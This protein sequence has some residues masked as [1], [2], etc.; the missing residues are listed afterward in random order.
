M[1]FGRPGRLQR[2][3]DAPKTGQ[4]GAR[5]GQVG[6]RTSPRRSKIALRRSEI[7]LRCIQDRLDSKISKFRKTL[8]KPNEFQGFCGRPG[9]L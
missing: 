6:A 3:Q 2:G 1:F 9:R 4:V 7:D 5:T 8:K